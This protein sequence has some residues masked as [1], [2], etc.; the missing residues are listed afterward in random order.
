MSKNKIVFLHKNLNF[1]FV[2]IC[3]LI[4]KQKI[5]EINNIYYLNYCFNS[6]DK[7]V[8]L[9]K[10]HNIKNYFVNLNHKFINEDNNILLSDKVFLLSHITLLRNISRQKNTGWDLIIDNNKYNFKSVLKTNILKFLKLFEIVSYQSECNNSTCYLINKQ[11]CKMFIIAY[12]FS[13]NRLY[14]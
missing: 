13:I 9:Q 14:S 1:L 8:I 7:S 10:G 11:G 6:Q 3:Y 5:K 12:I 4:N 2:V